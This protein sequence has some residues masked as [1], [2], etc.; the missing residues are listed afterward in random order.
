MCNEARLSH[1]ADTSAGL[2]SLPRADII[3]V[4]RFVM[5]NKLFSHRGIHMLVRTMFKGIAAVCALAALS[6]G[7]FAQSAIQTVSVSAADRAAASSV[8]S[9][10]LSA[11]PQGRGPRH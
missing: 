7:A 10:F 1:C 5:N 3:P 9:K 11:M 4:R 2:F 6:G 8:I